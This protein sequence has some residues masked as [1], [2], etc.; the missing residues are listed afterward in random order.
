MKPI[1]F[2]LLCAAEGRLLYG[3]ESRLLHG[4]DGRLLHGADGRLLYGAVGRL[5]ERRTFNGLDH[6][7]NHQHDVSS[8]KTLYPF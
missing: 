5:V 1:C 7:I 4:T 2:A 6:A 3:A 8:C